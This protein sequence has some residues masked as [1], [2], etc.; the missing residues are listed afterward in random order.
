[1]VHDAVLGNPDCRYAPKR[2][3]LQD[4]GSA[5]ELR[6]FYLPAADFRI[7]HTIM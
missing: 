2:E 6:T 1:M 3:I 7:R 5:E 4:H